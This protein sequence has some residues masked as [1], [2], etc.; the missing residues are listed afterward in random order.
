MRCFKVTYRQ[1]NN[2][3]L[4][5]GILLESRPL[6]LAVAPAASPNDKSAAALTMA[7]SAAAALQA[8]GMATTLHTKEEMLPWQAFYAM[9]YMVSAPIMVINLLGMI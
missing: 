3:H 8:T 9:S 7:T 1:Q 4:L 2:I 6:L 5:Q